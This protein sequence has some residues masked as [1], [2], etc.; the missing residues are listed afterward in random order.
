VQEIF[1]RVSNSIVELGYFDSSYFSSFEILWLAGSL[2]AA[3]Y[4][5]F[6]LTLCS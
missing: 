1:A 4:G 2:Y 5:F 3:I 6:G